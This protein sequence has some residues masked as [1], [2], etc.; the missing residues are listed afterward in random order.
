MQTTYRRDSSGPR[1]QPL[2][3]VLMPTYDHSR[4]ISRSIE[5]LLAQTCRDWELVIVDDASP[6][7]THAVVAPYLP[8]PRISYQKLNDNAGLG[9]ALNHALGLAQGKLIA[10]LPSDDIFFAEHLDSLVQCLERHQQAIAA[11]SGLRH[12]FNK[13]AQDL[14]GRWLQLVQVMH[15]RTEDAWIER[16]EL[17]TDDLDRM[18]WSKLRQRGTFARTGA[19]TCEWF[20]HPAQRHKVLREPFGG[21]NP[22]RSRYA[23][24][25]PLR[26]HT[27]VG[28]AIDEVEL[29]RRFRERP[30]TPASADALKILLVGEL[31][32]NAERVLA[33]EEAG[34]RLYGLWTPDPQWWNTVGPLPF[35][36][37]QDIAYRGWRDS[38]RKIKPDVIYALLNWPAIR[39]AHHVLEQNPGVPFV[40]HLKEA[41]TVAAEKGLWRELMDLYLRSDAQIYCSPEMRDW[42]F[43]LAPQ[44]RGK[45]W[46]VLDGD[47][48]KR[49]WLDGQRSRR[50]SERDGQIHTVVPGRPIGLHPWV[51]AEL[52]AQ[53]IHV[54]FYGDFTQDLWRKW[55]E[56]V[57]ETCAGF[58]HLHPNVDQRGW[59]TE[60]SQYDAGWLHFFR[61]RNAGETRRMVFDDMNYPARIG[62]LV[63]AGLPLLQADNRGSVVAMQNL[64]RE[65]EI[66]LFFEDA[67]QLREQLSDENGL[68]RIRDNVWR[69]RERFTF[70][71]H[72]AR[73]VVFFREATAL[74][75][76]TRREER[77]MHAAVD[78]DEAV[79]VSDELR[80]VRTV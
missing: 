5:S 61:S 79:R 64:A 41:P 46:L 58:L 35:G 28:N 67:V 68:Q 73:L 26:I 53:H 20:D 54:H 24:P 18:F 7:D 80:G 1:P 65:H 59:V 42:F 75:K 48:P 39:F 71:H 33:F 12:H 66:G 22:Y 63:A 9:A 6:D 57:R 76:Q 74:A 51:M 60:F 32:Y 50:L 37:V 45:P 4:F 36:H 78:M 77:L 70:D 19:V 2:V 14:E 43:A 56:K 38:V 69:Q 40:W 30:D 15:R 3:S 55:I 16:S 23:V 29:Y 11:S 44:L 52:A 34:H 62:P 8:D 25:Q 13:E 21:L 10:Y 49:D 27:S 31:A 72:A 47:L 17:V